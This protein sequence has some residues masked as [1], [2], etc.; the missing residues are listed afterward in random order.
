VARMAEIGR[1]ITRAEHVAITCEQVL[2]LAASGMSCRKMAEVLG[3][4]HSS[5]SNHKRALAGEGKA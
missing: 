2:E 1:F 3:L 4:S 5:V